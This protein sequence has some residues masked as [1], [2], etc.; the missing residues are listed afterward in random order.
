[1][2]DV[3]I[4]LLSYQAITS[5]VTKQHEMK[6]RCNRWSCFLQLRLVA[7]HVFWLGCV[8]DSLLKPHT[9]TH[10]KGKHA[11][12]HGILRCMSRVDRVTLSVCLLGNLV[13]RIRFDSP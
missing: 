5:D 8:A 2:A 1:M 6:L 9:L 10:Y 7:A 4:T 3:C 13:K 11:V 12:L